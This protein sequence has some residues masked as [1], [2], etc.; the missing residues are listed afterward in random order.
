[1]TRKPV[2]VWEPSDLRRFREHVDAQPEEWVRAAFRLT[3]CGLR[4]S[5]VLGL[6]L[7]SV[8]LD[9]GTVRV[10]AS[11]VKTGKGYET[12]R[13]DTKSAASTRTVMVDTMRPGTLA[14]LRA[15]GTRQAA[16]KLAA[17][18]AY[19][20]SGLAIVDALGRGIHPEVYSL[21]WRA[22]CKSAGLPTIRLHAARHALALMLHRA[23][24]AP[25]DVASMLGHS[26]G[27]HLTFYV[28]KTERGAASAATRLGELLAA[29]Q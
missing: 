16:D 27:T 20:E 13:D 24:V 21:R 7:E 17:G 15:L 26:V 19:A 4:R 18:P 29:A 2:A 1:V 9:A 23:G 3:A 22:L 14:A 28:P 12:Q 8:D 5:E 11:R 10:E 6:A 25:A